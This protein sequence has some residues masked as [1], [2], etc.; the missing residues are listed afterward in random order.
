MNCKPHKAY[1]SIQKSHSVSLH[2]GGVRDSP[3]YFSP[4]RP[5][6]DPS[7]YWPL[8]KWAPIWL[9]PT[10]KNRSQRRLKKKGLKCESKP[11][12]MKQK[13]DWAITSK[14]KQNIG[15]WPVCKQFTHTKT[16]IFPCFSLEML[17]STN[18]FSEDDKRE[19]VVFQFL[20]S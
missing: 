10:T 7:P 2:K 3:S 14:I 6:E 8:F 18:Q 15:Q 16:H 19:P 13:G 17:Y 12:T 20:A 9:Q 1:S 4:Q 11:W 5:Q